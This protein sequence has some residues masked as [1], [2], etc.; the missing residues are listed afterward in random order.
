M[1]QVLKAEPEHNPL[2]A[3]V[4][5]GSSENSELSIKN[6]SPLV[7]LFKNF[8]STKY[9]ESNGKSTTASMS[10]LSIEIGTTRKSVY[11][12]DEVSNTKP[13]SV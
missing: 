7:K 4:D 13:I 5:A 12:G 8:D 2:K 3:V 9:W 11:L 10:T 1:R 6:A